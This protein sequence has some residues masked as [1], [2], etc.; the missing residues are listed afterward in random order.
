MVNNLLAN[1]TPI[2][3]K[4]TDKRKE[5]T[6]LSMT[7]GFLNITNVQAKP[8]TKNTISTPAIALRTANIYID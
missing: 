7:V 3:T 4:A 1:R 2:V 8:G 6:N 5:K